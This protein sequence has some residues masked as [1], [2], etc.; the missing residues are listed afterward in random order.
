MARTCSRRG[1]E[2]QAVNA[3]NVRVV[4]AAAAVSSAAALGGVWPEGW[5]PAV[6]IVLLF[7]LTFIGVALV[8]LDR[9][10]SDP[11]VRT[12]RRRRWPWRSY[13]RRLRRER[14]ERSAEEQAIPSR[15]EVPEQSAAAGLFSGL[16]NDLA[17][18]DRRH[19]QARQEADE[20]ASN[21]VPQPPTLTLIH[22]MPGT[23]KSVLAR[24][25]LAK[26]TPL[27]P[28]GQ[29]FVNLG[30]AGV[31]EEPAQ[32]LHGLFRDLQWDGPIPDT[33]DGRKGRFR[34]LTGDKRM[35]FVLDAAR[36]QTQV[37][38]LLPNGSGCGVIVTSRRNL[39]LH[40]TGVSSWLVALPTMDEAL[41][42]LEAAA[43][44]E[45]LDP[46][47]AAEVVEWCGHLPVAI[48]AVAEQVA[49]DGTSFRDLA[50]FLQD[51]HQRFL[52]LNDTGRRFSDGIQGE[53]R[54]LELVEVRA[55]C[56][57]TAVESETFTSWVL[58]PMLNIDRQEA[59]SLIAR[60]HPLIDPV[61][62]DGTDSVPRY[63]FHPLTRLFAEDEIKRSERLK[64]YVDAA[65][66]RLETAYYQT[67]V[68]VA[69]RVDASFGHP[70]PPEGALEWLPRNRATIKEI[71][72]TRA[73]WIRVEYAN[74][75]RCARRALAG[76]DDALGWRVVAEL[77]VAVPRG[78]DRGILDQLFTD[79]QEAALRDGNRI[80]KVDVQ[81]AYG[82]HLIGLDEYDRAF[83]VLNQALDACDVL[84][85]TPD[86]GPAADSGAR[87]G[88]VTHPGDAAGHPADHVRACR[89]RQARVWLRMGEAYLQM[90]SCKQAS[91][92]LVAA[93]RT[94]TDLDDVDDQ[95]G[96]VEVLTAINNNM[97]ARRSATS[98]P[99]APDGDRSSFWAL[100]EQSDG[101]RR[102][103]Q[104]EAARQCLRR[105]AQLSRGDLRRE[106][107]TSYR[108][109]ST[110]V[111][112]WFAG[113]RAGPGAATVAKR[114][115]RQA[116]QTVHLFRR[117]GNQVGEARARFLLVRT[118][119]AAGR[120]TDA[121][122]HFRIASDLYDRLTLHGTLQN[123]ARE[124]LLARKHIAEATLE[125]TS[126][127]G[128][129]N[130][131]L[132]DAL[133][134]VARNDDA[135]GMDRVRRLKEELTS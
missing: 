83:A 84:A 69:R 77:G 28:D 47:C 49:L 1:G 40:F 108:L 95:L 53:Y 123:Q 135:R 10:S 106:A 22:G 104:W 116:G 98:V 68:E 62:R 58:R 128:L 89:L 93:R 92:C 71:A 18:L 24:E 129:A 131:R 122:V 111:D 54:Q 109:A 118:L 94:F 85:G 16:R 34:S 75:V 125:L 19:R 60:L 55:L 121:W 48:Q 74:V 130:Q 132:S 21:G 35:L 46:D 8:E 42:M 114:S 99:A 11:N 57:L 105:A 43:G 86:P 25:L 120:T 26:L 52:S 27:Y 41:E 79:A 59:E 15:I 103:S 33:L 90:R 7:F 61:D 67:I 56:C 4:G 73:R 51:P 17:E 50:R 72:A 66:A 23:G 124:T 64:R 119:V 5:P 39:D 133:Q 126:D 87:P 115:V 97:I 78:I 102:V 36:D 20:A 45:S 81:I 3:G 29:F 134:L 91:V 44:V 112:E 101:F 80:G 70:G 63:R 88:R 117:M 76:R 110:D 9:R 82:E 38:D 6:F 100:L 113:P 96:L 37:N 13:R 14:R 127:P 32:V 65:Q 107:N 31:A 2:Q 30:S 12:R